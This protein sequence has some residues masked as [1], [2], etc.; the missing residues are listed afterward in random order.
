M[1]KDI[2]LISLSSSVIILVLL[3]I[4][5]ILNRRYS[6]KWRYLLWLIIAIR[7]LV[8]YRVELNNAPINIPVTQKVVVTRNEGSAFQIMSP[9]QAEQGG[10]MNPDPA[11]YAPIANVDDIISQIWILGILVFASYHIICYV[12]FRKRIQP[13]LLSVDKNTYRCNKI[14]TPM[15]IGFF[16]PLI[17]LPDTDYTDEEVEIIIRHEITHFK[18]GDLWYKLLML[19][20]NAVHW[21][22]P[23]VYIMVRQ[24]N[25]DLEYFCDDAVTKDTDTNYKKIYSLTI[26]KTMKKRGEQ[27]EK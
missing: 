8:P 23:F 11:D 7:L 25:R 26:L 22:N 4:F 21:F 24:A 6:A 5:P 12:T 19:A 14:D 10:I 1:F 2:L 18:R 13:Y 16:K 20:A 9:Q 3:V 17:L 15:M 27:N